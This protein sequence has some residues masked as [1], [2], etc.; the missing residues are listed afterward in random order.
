MQ[1]RAIREIDIDRA[2][3]IGFRFHRAGAIFF[4]LGRQAS[5]LRVDRLNGLTVVLSPRGQVMTVYKNPRALKDLR[6]KARYSRYDRR[7]YLMGA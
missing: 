6:S 3:A 5:A 7:S 4:F 1:Q 2:L